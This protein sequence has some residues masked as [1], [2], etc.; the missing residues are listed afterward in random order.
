[1]KTLDFQNPINFGSQIHIVEVNK[2]G[3]VSSTADALL[4]GALS[5][6]G[7]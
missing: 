4:S 3:A 2:G 1:M 5:G 7:G 6:G